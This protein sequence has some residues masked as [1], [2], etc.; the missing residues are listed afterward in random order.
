MPGAAKRYPLPPSVEHASRHSELGAHIEKSRGK[1]VVIKTTGRTV[2]DAV[3]R[4]LGDL[5]LLRGFWTLIG[6]YGKWSFS[7]GPP[8][9]KPIGVIH[10]G[11][12][13]TVHNLD[14]TLAEDVYWHE[15]E[16]I[17]IGKPFS[18]PDGWGPIEKRRKWAQRRLRSL[19]YRAEVEDIV[20]RYATALDQVNL[21]VALLHLW[22]ILEKIT[23]TVGGKYDETIRRAVWGFNDR[24]LAAE[25]LQTVRLH[26]NQFVHAA[27]SGEDRDQ[28]VYMIKAFVEPHLL[29]LL[30]N[31]FEVES[32]EEYARFLSQPTNPAALSRIHRRSGRALWLIRAWSKARP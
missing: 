30:R 23:D 14:G 20:S 26:R 12:V 11:P 22:S 3:S 5:T 7:L 1:H 15:L 25:M 28:I 32:L 29:R 19:P 18:P 27:R 16:F 2:H 31:D 6:T 10:A 21:D 9:Q 4:G 24:R 8:K 17:E 13:H